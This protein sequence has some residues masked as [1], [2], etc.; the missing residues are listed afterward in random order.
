MQAHEHLWVVLAMAANRGKN[1]KESLG[2]LKDHASYVT[3]TD[4]IRSEINPTPDGRL[5]AYRPFS[6]YTD[7]AWMKLPYDKA[8]KNFKRIEDVEHYMPENAER[9]A[10][11]G[12]TSIESYLEHNKEYLENDKS[13]FTTAH[14]LQDAVIDRIMQEDIVTTYYEAEIDPNVDQSVSLYGN[15]NKGGLCKFN[16]TGKIAG[17]SD[18]RDVVILFSALTS[19]KLWDQIKFS[20]PDLT[21]DEAT[22][23]IKEAYYRDY[24]EPMANAAIQFA[25]PN[26]NIEKLL[27]S[28]MEESVELAGKSINSLE[29]IKN[30]LVR[31]S[32]F[33][34]VKEVEGK[35]DQT[36]RECVETYNKT[37]K[38]DGD[39]SDDMEI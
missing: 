3:I 10:A 9:K 26:P 12:P 29:D 37:F 21:I 23:A 8:L 35:V 28:D 5:K 13:A 7:G 14:L 34:D 30:E 16:Y 31:M 32:A 20:Y 39:P 2:L 38:I 27:E 17:M 1:K 18:F 15:E 33:N 24:S 4:S 11:D 6:H 22:D 19:S 25:R 36:I